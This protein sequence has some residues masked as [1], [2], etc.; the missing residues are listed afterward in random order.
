[1]MN[2]G[3]RGHL[4]DGDMLGTH[5]DTRRLERVLRGKH[6]HAVIFPVC[7]DTVRR[8]SLFV[9]S[10]TASTT[11]GQSESLTYDEEMPWRDKN[12]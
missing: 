4:T 7:I 9:L 10:S 1:M 6:D 8:P 12:A 2:V 3:H 5:L 11:A